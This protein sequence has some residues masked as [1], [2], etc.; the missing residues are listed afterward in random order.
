MKTKDIPLTSFDIY[1][2]NQ[3]I[4]NQL[5]NKSKPI[6]YKNHV[7]PDIHRMDE[8]YISSWYTSIRKPNQRNQY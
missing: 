6:M 7:W 1:R 3:P 5:M 8:I 2:T 4:L